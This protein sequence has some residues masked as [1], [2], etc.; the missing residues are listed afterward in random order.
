MT[1]RPLLL[2]GKGSTLVL[3]L[4]FTGIIAGL[5]VPFFASKMQDDYRISFRKSALKQALYQANGGID[6][7]VTYIA[8]H[9]PVM[10]S[11]QSEL[12]FTTFN[13]LVDINYVTIEPTALTDLYKVTA[14]ATVRNVEKLITVDVRKNPPAFVLDYIYF[15]NNMGWLY[16]PPD[17]NFQAWGDV[18][19]N[20][21]FYFFGKPVV[22]GHVFAH[23][24][25][26][27]RVNGPALRGQHPGVDQL[28]MPNLYDLEIYKGMAEEWDSSVRI[29]GETKID[30]VFNGNIYL[31]GTEEDPIVIDGPVVV[32]GDVIIKGP[33]T[34]QGTIYAGRNIYI[35]DNITY[36]D[37][38]NTPRATQPGLF[39]KAQW[40]EQ[41]MDKDLLVLAAT[42]N[43]L[44]G[45]V[46]SG[47][48]LNKVFYGEG[49]YWWPG[50]QAFGDELHIG[51]DG[52]PGTED[53]DIPYDHDGDP[54]TPPTTWYDLDGDGVVDGNYDYTDD[55]ALGD[56][57]TYAN[58][59]QHNG[60]PKPFSSIATNDI[61]LMEMVAFTNHAFAGLSTDPERLTVNGALIGKDMGILYA[62]ALFLNYDERIHSRYLT[63]PSR[64]LNLGLPVAEKSRILSWLEVK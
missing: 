40:V 56:L 33:V 53:D 50:L 52:I 59:P 14:S 61:E 30:Q 2:K 8:T 7:A 6:F 21:D 9:D 26:I 47:G 44:Y 64:F 19:S 32:T 3:V 34:G 63:D 16:R 4:V 54:S 31:A 58:Y 57:A 41:N 36:V 60:N 45:D 20:G 24:D 10:P 28:V 43:I 38:P 1:H 25:I 46:T 62:E 49:L 12:Q 13:D 5:L 23:L 18:R 55:V 35:A 48:W 17:K 42:E 39:H 37:G 22:H 15:V 27:G 51:A 11:L 29:A